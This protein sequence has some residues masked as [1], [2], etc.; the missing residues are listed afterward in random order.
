[1]SFSSSTGDITLTELDHVRLA[2]LARRG[3]PMPAS[4][5]E[6]LDGAEIVP[7]RQVPP[8]VVTMYAR[9][10]FAD[11]EGRRRAL[12]V[13]Y[14]DDAEPE[15]GFVSVLSPLGAALIGCRA[16]DEV[17]WLTPDGRCHT[18]RIDAV[19]F[20]PEASGDFTT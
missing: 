20:Q 16:G 18:G 19:D 1:M 13:C 12:V 14:P 15:A 3:S 7:S 6:R 2:A 9:L 11:A 10:Q 8:D 5:S 17:A 4:L